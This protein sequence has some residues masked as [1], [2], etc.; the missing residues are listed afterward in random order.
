MSAKRS[1]RA[2]RHDSDRAT[3]GQ[4]AA[5]RSNSAEGASV[6]GSTL[7]DDDW[8]DRPT[9][10]FCGAARSYPLSN[11]KDQYARLALSSWSFH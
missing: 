1:D 6:G 3:R 5:S 10:E 4:E 2:S 9:G 11:D 7:G 8:L